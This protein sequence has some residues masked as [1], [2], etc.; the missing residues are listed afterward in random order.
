MDGDTGEVTHSDLI[1]CPRCTHLDRI[2][3]WDCDYGE[4]KYVD[5]EHSVYCSACNHE[6]QI[7]THC[8]YE[9][10]SPPVDAP[11]AATPSDDEGH[12]GSACTVRPRMD[13]GPRA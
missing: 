8:S 13:R 12:E 7:T 1:R 10:T 5:G 2:S 6:Y 4:E 11:K 3:D 9:Y